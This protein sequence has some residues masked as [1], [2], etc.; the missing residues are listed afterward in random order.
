MFIGLFQICLGEGGGS[1]DMGFVGGGG[2]G[3]DT[4]ASPLCINPWIVI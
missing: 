4:R 2:G 1:G 3:G